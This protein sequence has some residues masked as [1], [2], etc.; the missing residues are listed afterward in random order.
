MLTKKI[1]YATGDT[2]LNDAIRNY[3]RDFD[4]SQYKSAGDA[5][6]REVVLN[7]ISELNPDIVILS[8]LL[9]GQAPLMQMIFD[10]KKYFPNLRIIYLTGHDD[11]STGKLTQLVIYN[12]YDFIAADEWNLDEIVNLI[13]NPKT[14]SDVQ[15][16]L[17][18]PKEELNKNQFLAK[19][20]DSVQDEIANN[21]NRRGV[22][23]TKNEL[24]EIITNEDDKDRITSIGNNPVIF[25]K[26][27][28]IGNFP[29]LVKP[30]NSFKSSSKP[31]VKLDNLEEAIP[32][33]TP[34]KIET[35][36]LEKEIKQTK[37]VSS[38]NDNKDITFPTKEMHKHEPKN[39]MKGLGEFDQS[40]KVSQ[41]SKPKTEVLQPQNKPV[42]EP[43]QPKPENQSNKE[44]KMTDFKAK[45]VLSYEQDNN[46]NPDDNKKGVNLDFYKNTFEKEVNKIKEETTD[47]MNKNAKEVLLKALESLSAD[48]ISKILDKKL[49]N[50]PSKVEEDSDEAE[51]TCELD[52][53]GMIV[54]DNKP[55][56]EPEKKKV[57]IPPLSPFK[58][59]VFLKT[60]NLESPTAINTAYYL[61]SD[62]KAKVLYLAYYDFGAADALTKEITLN[63]GV[64]EYNYHLPKKTNIIGRVDIKKVEFKTDLS[65]L[66][67]LTKGY[68]YIVW[69]IDLNE[70]GSLTF[71]DMSLR[72]SDNKLNKVY[73]TMVQ[74]YVVYHKLTSNLDLYNKYGDLK[75]ILEHPVSEHISRKTIYNKLGL[76]VVRV[77][78]TVTSRSGVYNNASLIMT[79]ANNSEA[80]EIYDE[81]FKD[82]RDEKPEEREGVITDASA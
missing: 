63:S 29:T 7:K 56:K 74:D 43:M 61:A 44:V 79:K 62:R 78:D 53:N 5:G 49:G 4:A 17:P 65:S 1:L 26:G 51:F 57:V 71:L 46:S 72:N 77:Y 22:E 13:K 48:D 38:N 35:P 39:L 80:Y 69:D 42:K 24:T 8:D 9:S 20:V 75:V 58:N 33:T 27:E 76:M 45:D 40:H 41:T 73:F 37:Q 16:Y 66:K 23:V 81:L 18:S 82:I 28:K 14:L 60:N 52:N 47:I 2:D 21:A 59:F 68:D 70:D 30:T 11:N 55:K 12:V 15:V 10:I 32:E 6:Y 67:D 50:K 34:L 54:Q 25:E 3:L 36:V 19:H 64:K 31:K